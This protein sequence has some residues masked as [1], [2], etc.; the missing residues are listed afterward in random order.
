VFGSKKGH[1]ISFSISISRATLC[2]SVV[3]IS[4]YRNVNYLLFYFRGGTLLKTLTNRRILASRDETSADIEPV[5]LACI[6][7]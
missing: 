5:L 6:A 7:M 2:V 1:E 3:P 4:M